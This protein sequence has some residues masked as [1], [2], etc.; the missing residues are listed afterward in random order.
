MP[1]VEEGAANRRSV[2]V[3]FSPRIRSFEKSECGFFP[4][5]LEERFVTNMAR[6]SVP[7]RLYPSRNYT[8]NIMSFN[9]KRHNDTYKNLNDIVMF[10]KIV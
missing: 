5:G 9:F 4:L 6:F 1:P 2:P 8:C 7:R 3:G 10:S